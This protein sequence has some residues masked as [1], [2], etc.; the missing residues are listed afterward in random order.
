MLKI[1]YLF[2]HRTQNRCISHN[3]KKYYFG[4]V[5]PVKTKNSLRIQNFRCSPEETFDP[6]LS[7]ERPAILI[8]LCRAESVLADLS[9][10]TYFSV[11]TLRIKYIYVR[12]YV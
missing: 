5:R 1:I 8:R 6:W 9:D 4:H 7:R 11:L 2:C 10:G 12:S 3:V